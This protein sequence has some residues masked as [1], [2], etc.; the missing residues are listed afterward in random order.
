M[1][2]CLACGEKLFHSKL[3]SCRDCYLGLGYPV[4]YVVCDKCDLVQQHP[5]PEDVSSFY[6]NYP[7]HQQRTIL[8]RFARRVLQRQVYHRPRSDA[9][10]KTLIDYGCGDGVY[11]R[12]MAGRYKSRAGYEPDAAHADQLRISL[13]LPVY[14][15]IDQMITEWGGQ[16]DVITAHYVMEHVVDL[17]KT[18]QTFYKLL[19]PEGIVHVA[20]PN[21]HSWEAR[22]F[23]KLWHGLDPPRHI[24]FP[25]KKSIQLLAQRSGLALVEH[26]YAIFPNTLAASIVAVLTGRYHPTLF[27][28]FILPC[29]FIAM[30]APSGTEVFLLEKQI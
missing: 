9:A 11:L 4:D 12:E 22:L 21:V 2:S 24:S 29:W 17:N 8:Q 16:V 27:N 14:S 26:R 18:M 19:K 20:V 6:A 10:G 28:L 25:N 13:G 5:I 23:G 30:C 7:V 1:F 3:A 15:D